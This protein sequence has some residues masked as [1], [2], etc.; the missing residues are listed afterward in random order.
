VNRVWPCADLISEPELLRT[1]R[2]AQHWQGDVRGSADTWCVGALRSTLPRSPLPTT[3]E[4]SPPRPTAIV[5]VL[6]LATLPVAHIPRVLH[7]RA[8]SARGRRHHALSERGEGAGVGAVAAGIHHA[9]WPVDFG[10]GRSGIDHNADRERKQSESSADRD[11][12]YLPNM[13]C[14]LIQ[15]P[16]RTIIPTPDAELLWLRPFCPAHIINTRGYDFREG[17]PTGGVSGTRRARGR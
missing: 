17:Q 16:M 11:Y 1:T 14:L 9:P 10:A 7:A 15:H 12:G 8:A 4:L 3:R 6:S 5:A 2:P 13:G